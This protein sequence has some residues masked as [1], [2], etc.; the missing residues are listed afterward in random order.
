VDREARDGD[1]LVIDYAPV[2][3][4]GEVDEKAMVRNH[5]VHLS[6]QNLF[7]EFRESLIGMQL[8]DEKRITVKYPDDFPEKQL[9]GTERTFFVSLR[10]I[11]EKAL[12]DLNDAFASQVREDIS[13]LKTLREKI[14]EDL[15]KEEQ[16]RLRH[17]AE[18]RIIDA[19]IEAN[20]FE[21]PES[22]VENYLSSIIEEDR[23]KR[24]ASE[25]EAE[26]EAE[27]RKLF[28][29]T[30]V[31]AV[32]RYFILDAVAEQENLEV[33]RKE[34]EERVN[35]I[36][37]GRGGEEKEIRAYFR[38]PENR[39]SLENQVLDEKVLNFLHGN[40]DIQAS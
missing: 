17:E 6:S 2:L 4:S 13:D 12:P 37:E 28:H 23:K 27:I 5:G 7:E 34:L 9:A 14:H 33:T 18:E 24:P 11:K 39:R 35:R 16:R 19:L 8:R 15:I 25:D 30:A 29:G 40:A 26:R 22:M 20:P 32:K 31:R 10:E 3:D 38:R 1:F 36:A 21:A